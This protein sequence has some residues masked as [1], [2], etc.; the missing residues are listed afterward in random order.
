MK[1]NQNIKSS[2]QSYQSGCSVQARRSSAMKCPLS[3][4]INVENNG[5][6]FYSPTRR[7]EHY[8]PWLEDKPSHEQLQKTETETMFKMT[9]D[10]ESWQ[11]VPLDVTWE[12]AEDDANYPC[13]DPSTSRSRRSGSRWTRRRRCSRSTWCAP[14]T[15]RPPPRSPPSAGSSPRSP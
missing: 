15:R 13:S 1:K 14:T 5:L 11:R 2:I 3:N 9:I 4:L 10:G 12:L 7:Y 8:P 6:F